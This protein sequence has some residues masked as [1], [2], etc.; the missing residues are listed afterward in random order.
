[1]AEL[2]R[3]EGNIPGIKTKTELKTRAGIMRASVGAVL[4]G[5]RQGGGCGTQQPGIGFYSPYGDKK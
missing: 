3:K 1:M 2:A 4:G 5:H